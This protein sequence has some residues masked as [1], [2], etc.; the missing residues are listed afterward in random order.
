MIAYVRHVCYFCGLFLPLNLCLSKITYAYVVFLGPNS[1]ILFRPVEDGM[2]LYVWWHTF[3]SKVTG[4]A[5]MWMCYGYHFLWPQSDCDLG[6]TF[7][8]KEG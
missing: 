8:A 5:G 7:F 4:D 6:N 2:L 3:P 1:G